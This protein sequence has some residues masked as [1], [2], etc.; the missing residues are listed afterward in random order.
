MTILVPL[1]LA[2]AFVAFVIAIFNPPWRY[3]LIALGL[4]AWVLTEL[5]PHLG[6]H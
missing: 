5:L 6:L 4:A 1:L 2:V 3:N